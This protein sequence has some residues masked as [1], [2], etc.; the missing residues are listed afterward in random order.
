MG[1]L[2]YSQISHFISQVQ[3]NELRTKIKRALQ[4]GSCSR[5][6]EKIQL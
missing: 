2:S 1:P 3:Y 4:E 5:A 6:S